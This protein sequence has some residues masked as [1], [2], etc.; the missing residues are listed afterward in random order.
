[1]VLCHDGSISETKA[2]TI[3]EFPAAVEIDNPAQPGLLFIKISAGNVNKNAAKIAI[4]LRAIPPRPPFISVERSI[5][6][7]MENREMGEY[8]FDFP[9]EICKIPCQYFQEKFQ[10]ELEVPNLGLKMA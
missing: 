8:I 9:Q 7:P 10:Q 2:G 3:I 1:M 5:P 4:R 6:A